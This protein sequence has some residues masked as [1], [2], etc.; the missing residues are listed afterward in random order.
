MSE[1]KKR[2]TTLDHPS[3]RDIAAGGLA[4]LVLAA[5]AAGADKATELDGELLGLCRESENLTAELDRINAALCEIPHRGGDGHPLAQRERG[6]AERFCELREMIAEQTARTPEGIRAKAQ[7]A[8][9]DFSPADE[10]PEDNSY[11]I[12]WSLAHDILGRAGA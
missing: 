12:V 11:W 7:A 10:W 8:L 2:N 4:M 3:R 6:A 9:I 5:A 1:A